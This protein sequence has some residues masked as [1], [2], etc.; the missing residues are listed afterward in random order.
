MDDLGLRDSGAN[1]HDVAARSFRRERCGGGRADWL[2]AR[3][4]RD[5]QHGRIARRLGR[6]VA[7]EPLLGRAQDGSYLG[8]VCFD[9]QAAEAINGLFP[10]RGAHSPGSKNDVEKRAAL[11]ARCPQ[12]RLR[13]VGGGREASAAMCAAKVVTKYSRP[14]SAENSA[15]APVSAEFSGVAS[16]AAAP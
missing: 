6:D 16:R 8:G 10:K 14:E 5:M 2:L 11:A 4:L 12:R 9:V 7:G 3:E 15:Y 1:C 13:G